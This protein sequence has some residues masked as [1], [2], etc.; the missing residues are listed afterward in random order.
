MMTRALLALTLL[1]SP[2]FA[3]TFAP[4][5]GC[6]ATLTV[7]SRGCT[8][9][10]FYTCEKDPAG[11][12]WRADFGPEG[13]YYL[14]M[15]DRETQ[16]VES[17][18]VDAGGPTAKET[19]DP[20]AKDPASL[21][22]LIDTG[23]DTFDFNLTKSTGE[24]SHVTGFDQLTGKTAVID[25]QTLRQTEYEFTQT[26]EKGTVLRHSKGREYISEEFRS[27]FSGTSNWESEDGTWMTVE[28]SPITFIKPGEP[29]FASTLPLF[30]CDDQMSQLL[31]LPHSVAP[32]K[33]DPA[34]DH[35]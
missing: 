22:T 24:K 21:S 9:S 30:E 1:A 15:I 13:M 2:A 12:Q 26:D 10:H 19:L 4:P 32:S 11:N 7:Q 27:F 16:W 3:A 29:G 20:G 34:H 14:S 31:P 6:T 8:V 35:L 5:A 25:G 28:G 17:Y 23:L 33:K 18:E